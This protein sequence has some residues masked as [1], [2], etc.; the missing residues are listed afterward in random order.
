MFVNFQNTF[1]HK[2]LLLD[3]SYYLSD[4]NYKK[5][6]IIM[7]LLLCIQ[8]VMTC[9]ARIG[10]VYTIH[11]PTLICQHVLGKFK[12]LKGYTWK[13]DLIVILKCLQNPMYKDCLKR[14]SNLHMKIQ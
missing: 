9:N 8:H 13:F 2:L 14:V 11:T 10:E 3:A 6:I 5:N 1:K 12:V 4:S 7:K